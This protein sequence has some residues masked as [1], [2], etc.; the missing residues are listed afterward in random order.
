MTTSIVL[1]FF[2]GIHLGHKAVIEGALNYEYPVK[3]VT[4][5]KSPA[6]YFTGKAEYIFERNDSYDRIKKLGVKDIIVEDFR[7]ISDM[8]NFHP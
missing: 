3:L 6:E 2:D 7:I 8:V 5:N 1:G 4:L